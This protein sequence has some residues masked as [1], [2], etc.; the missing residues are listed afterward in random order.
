MIAGPAACLL[1]GRGLLPVA[2][3][4]PAAGL[5]RWGPGWLPRLGVACSVPL[6]AVAAGLALRDQ[7]VVSAAARWALAS[8][9]GM[10]F[11]RR[12]GAVRLGL[13]LQ[14]VGTRGP[15]GSFARELGSVVLSASR[16][17]ERVA[18]RRSL[19]ELEAAMAEETGPGAGFPPE[20]PAAP[21]ILLAW[22][23]AAA[24]ALLLAG[25]AGF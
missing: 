21:D 3:A 17:R 8:A 14:G 25:V 11:A 1:I 23:G 20:A 24:W 6:A 5:L 7:S 16:I 18:A 15:L 12:V 13:A 2:A 4:F 22:E 10:Y 9:T 19:L